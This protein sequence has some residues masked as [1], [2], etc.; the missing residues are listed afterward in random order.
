MAAHHSYAEI[1]CPTC[2]AVRTTRKDCIT[3][4]LKKGRSL[5]CKSC[6]MRGRA[7]TKKPPEELVVNHPSYTNYACAIRRCRNGAKHHKSYEGIE[8]R[9]ESFEEFCEAL[10][11]KPSPQH[12]VDR[13]NPLGHYERGNVRWATRKEQTANRMPL[14]CPHC[15]R[16]GIENMLRYH[17]DNCKHKG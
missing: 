13:I 16:V 3:N 9:F 7:L 2:K 15:G 17:F 4:A 8:F 5:E 14:V 1:E 11:E 10:G 12:T 6:A